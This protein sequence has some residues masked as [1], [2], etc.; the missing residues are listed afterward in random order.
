[1]LSATAVI[2]AGVAL[3]LREQPEAALDKEQT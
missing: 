1:M 3:V 2:L